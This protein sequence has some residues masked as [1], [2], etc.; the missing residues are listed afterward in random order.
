MGDYSLA[1]WGGLARFL[2]ENI[3][4]KRLARSCKSLLEDYLSCVFQSGRVYSLLKSRSEPTDI[5]E[6]A[7]VPWP[8]SGDI[9]FETLEVDVAKKKLVDCDSTSSYERMRFPKT[10]QF[11]EGVHAPWHTSHYDVDLDIKPYGYPGPCDIM[12]I[13]FLEDVRSSLEEWRLVSTSSEMGIR[14]RRLE[15][16]RTVDKSWHNVETKERPCAVLLEELLSSG[17]KA[18]PVADKVHLPGGPRIFANNES[19]PVKH[20]SYF[21]CLVEIEM[22]FQ[23]GLQ[24]LPVGRP[25]TFYQTVLET[26]CFEHFDYS[27]R[28]KNQSSH[29]AEADVV[30][31]GA[32]HVTKVTPPSLVLIPE[33]RDLAPSAPTVGAAANKNRQK[34]LT[35]KMER[36][37]ADAEEYDDDDASTL[38]WG[39]ISDNEQYDE[40]LVDGMEVEEEVTV[41][42]VG[43][44]GSVMNN[45]VEEVPI[46]SCASLIP[47][48]STTSSVVGVPGSGGSGMPVLAQPSSSSDEIV[49]EGH[50]LTVQTHGETG[51]PGY[52]QRYHVV[53]PQH[54]AGGRPCAK[55]R[56]I[57]ANQCSEYG[58][59]QPAAYLGVWLKAAG[60]FPDRV[61][62]M[63]YAPPL[64]D[65]RSYMEAQNWLP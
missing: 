12:T 19:D 43:G 65:V 57:G 11:W 60:C 7:F 56:N 51:A 9:L 30:D 26:S 54:I 10:V 40:D 22:L 5:H 48:P 24:Q 38:T 39:I 44:G 63:Q 29:P 20:R 35:E 46:G 3:A 28:R 4:S 31:D 53:C 21:C 62:H 15:H 14:S 23:K 1:E 13:A 41:E 18:G 55:R 49:V 45:E 61:A 37:T 8:P 36:E 6:A 64:A 52:Y 50:R 27:V 59:M 42:E 34:K 32:I 16:V 58:R 25:K 17:W 2:K 33:W 47:K